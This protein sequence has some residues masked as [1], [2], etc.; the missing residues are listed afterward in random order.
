MYNSIVVT[1]PISCKNKTIK[2]KF[3]LVFDKINWK[4]NA[5]LKL[6][7]AE[8]I[9]ILEGDLFSKVIGY[10]NPL[11]ELPFDPNGK[12]YDGPELKIRLTDTNSYTQWSN[13]TNLQCEYGKAFRIP[14]LYVNQEN[15]NI[16]T[17]VIKMLIK[18]SDDLFKDQI[19]QE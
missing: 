13:M 7:D 18:L 11:F 9:V 3:T 19:N 1:N 4:T 15:Q 2:Y 12:V 6:Y 8:Y 14:D 5:S 16:Y 10:I 17:N